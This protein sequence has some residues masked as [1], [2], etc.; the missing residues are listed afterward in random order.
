MKYVLLSGYYGYDNIGDEAVLGGILAGLRAELPEVEPVVLSG[1][2][3]FTIKLHG[4]S[5]IPRMSLRPI[6]ERL[7]GASLFIS[8]GGSLLQDVTSLRSPFYYLGM[9]WLAQRAG[10]PTMML[11]QGVGP[12]Q[13]FL[14][15]AWTRRVLN[16]TKAITVR[17]EGSANLLAALGVTV[18]AEVTADPSF[19]LEP[20][21]SERLEEWWAANIPDGRPVIGVALR[22]W[23][24]PDAYD[25]YHAI[26]DALAEMA[27]RTGALL[28]FIPMQ[29]GQDLHVS[30]EMAGWTPAESRVLNLPLTPREMLALVGRVDFI[31]AMRL[32]T[33]I[34]ATH[35]AVP[36]FGLSYDPKVADFCVSANLPTP[37]PWEA[38]TTSAL[39]DTLQTEWAAREAL[40][41]VL[42]ESAVR[43]TAKAKQN[44][45][46]V[47]ELL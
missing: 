17:D 4:V 43:L 35:R 31:L 47:G 8:G 32:H 3:A 40:R 20:D 29:A 1:D 14:A 26:S 21:P 24:S 7:K 25:R 36:A 27:R 11:A 46:R 19:L 12:L 9:L 16:R 13:H 44:I 34:F 15:R 33:L 41:G 42:R 18:P 39:V 22:Q 5:A 28:L 10:V 23:N 45:T 2:P 37:M 38:I 6:R 30:E